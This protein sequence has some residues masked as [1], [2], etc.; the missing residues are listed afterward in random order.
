MS[1]EQTI[2]LIAGV[3]LLVTVPIFA[4]TIRAIYREGTKLEAGLNAL[5]A[6]LSIFGGLL[7]ERKD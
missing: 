6:F 4:Y 2:L 1:D 5:A 3:A 7:V